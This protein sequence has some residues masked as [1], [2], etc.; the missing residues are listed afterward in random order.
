MAEQVTKYQHEDRRRDNNTG[1]QYNIPGR[2]KIEREDGWTQQQ[3]KR[4]YNKETTKYNQMQ[5]GERRI[6]DETGRI[7]E[8]NNNNDL[9]MGTLKNI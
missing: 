4:I 1:R 5:G 3:E 9:N 6:G 8:I 7:G 2:Y